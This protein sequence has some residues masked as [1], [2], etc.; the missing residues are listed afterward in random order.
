MESD[1][2]FF[3]KL[4]I[5]DLLNIIV[6]IIFIVFYFIG[7]ENTPYKVTLAIWY[8]ILFLFIILIS[9]L[10]Q[11]KK[12]FWG[13]KFLF[14]AYPLI[15]FFSLF[16]SFFM[17]LPYFNQIRYDELMINID[18]FLFGVHP[19]V[20]IEHIINPF[21][22]ELLYISYFFYFPM[23]L[24]LVILLF[25][26]KQ[27]KNL[28]ESL[29]L[30]FITYYGA[31][32]TYFFVPVEGPRFHLADI[33]TIPLTGILLAEP[34]LSVIDFFEPNK[35]DCFPSLHAAILIVTMYLTFKNAKKLFYFYLPFAFL[36]MISLV[37]CRF[38]YVIDIIAGTALAVLSI[39]FGRIAYLKLRNRFIFHFNNSEL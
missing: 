4:S 17:I 7:F 26:R 6:L 11:S 24:I 10:R 15:F 29:I 25:Y 23:P 38:H 8:S 3:K 36:I 35:L 5:I 1:K 33:Q 37:Y 39:S 32:I 16:E 31:Y 18:L 22:T 19:T 30:L 20:W 12:E 28:E 2:I 9:R 27:Y 34:I 14:L 13:K 21:L